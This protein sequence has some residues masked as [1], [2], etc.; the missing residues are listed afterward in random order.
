VGR[1]G[2]NN[3]KTDILRVRSKRKNKILFKKNIDLWEKIIPFIPA[4]SYVQIHPHSLD[5]QQSPHNPQSKSHPY[6]KC[7]TH[8][9]NKISEVQ[10]CESFRQWW[11]ANNNTQAITRCGPF[12]GPECVSLSWHI[13]SS[14]F[15]GLHFLPFAAILCTFYLGRCTMDAIPCITE[16]TLAWWASQLHN[17]VSQS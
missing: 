11:Y 1:E 5:E 3:T 17:I 2:K 12:P 13:C 15:T 16:L 9:T 14:S 8:H 4:G 7:T 10:V 6:K